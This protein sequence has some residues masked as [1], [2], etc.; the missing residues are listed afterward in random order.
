MAFPY[1]MKEAGKAASSY[2]ICAIK[3]ATPQRKKMSTNFQCF[4]Y[5]L[6]TYA[7]DNVIAGA[8]A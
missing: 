4:D 8:E 6:V 7:T 1:Y 3:T 2:H 5:L